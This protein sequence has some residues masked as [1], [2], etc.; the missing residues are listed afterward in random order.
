MLAPKPALGTGLC[1]LL[2]GCYAIE[3]QHRGKHYP[4]GWVLLMPELVLHGIRDLSS[5]SEVENS[6]VGTTP[7]TDSDGSPVFTV[8]ISADLSTTINILS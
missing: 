3:N 5:T 8:F 6:G 1:S 4:I 7:G 2:P